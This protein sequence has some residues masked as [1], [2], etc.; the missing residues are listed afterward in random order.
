VDPDRGLVV[1]IPARAT[2]ADAE[3]AV[4]ELDGWIAPRL[5]ALEDRRRR[6]T[7]QVAAGLP[8]LGRTLVLEP[9]EGRRRVHRDDDR[10]L[11]PADDAVRGPALTAWYRG[12][13]RIE[14]AARLDASMGALGRRYERLRVTDTRS[15]WGSCSS[16]GTISLSW[17]LLL[18]PEPC[19]DYVVWHE[20]CHLVHAHHGPEFWA[21][22]EEHVPDFREP[23]AWLREHGTDLRLLLPG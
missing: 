18:A 9:Q 15:R 3:R 11:V 12:R 1:T 2:V 20:A 23:S 4:V 13:A 8:Y 14:C 19:L 7:A 16:T 6:A 21:L 22:L 5:Q 17:R 10:L